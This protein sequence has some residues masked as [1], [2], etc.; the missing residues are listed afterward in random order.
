LLASGVDVNEKD[1]IGQSALHHAT[2]NN[3]VNVVKVQC[4]T[5]SVNHIVFSS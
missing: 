1:N 5:W 2:S 4:L 3:S